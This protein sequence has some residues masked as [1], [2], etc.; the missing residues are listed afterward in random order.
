MQKEHLFAGNLKPWRRSYLTVSSIDN[1]NFHT[2]DDY[3][4]FDE[5]SSN[6]QCKKMSHLINQD[7]G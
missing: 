1:G 6:S 5:R 4:Y 7:A 2:R 3:L